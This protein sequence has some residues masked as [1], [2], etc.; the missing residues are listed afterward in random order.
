MYRKLF[1]LIITLSFIFGGVFYTASDNIVSA[2]EKKCDCYCTGSIKPKGVKKVKS[3][4][5]SSLC[6]Q[7]CRKKNEVVAV[8]AYS[9]K[10]APSNSVSCF[11]QEQCSNHF[12]KDHPI[13]TS[14]FGAEQPSDCPVN[15]HSCYSKKKPGAGKVNLS[16]SIGTVKTVNNLGEYL[17]AMYKWLLGSGSVIAVILIMI[18]GLQYALGGLSQDQVAKA[19]KRISNAVIGLVLMVSVVIIL[20]VVNPQLLKIEPPAMPLIKPLV[21]ADGQSC[22]YYRDQ[23]KYKKIGEPK[24]RDGKKGQKKCGN[25]SDL[26]ED[27][28]GQRVADGLTCAWE[29]CSD[30][31]DKQNGPM[32]CLHG[33]NEDRCTRCGELYD[34]NSDISKAGIEIS[35]ALCSKYSRGTQPLGR[36]S[37]VREDCV[38]TKDGDLNQGIGVM[39]ITSKGACGWMTLACGVI[40]YTGMGGIKPP[41]IKTC[42]EY[43][44]VPVYNKIEGKELLDDLDNKGSGVGCAGSCSN[45]SIQEV[46]ADDPC[47]VG[48][49]SWVGGIHCQ[50][51]PPPSTPP[52][53]RTIYDHIKV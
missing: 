37:T 22:E 30:T 25:Y 2:Q 28:K 36:N 3:Q 33:T 1:G 21:L 29:G 53:P 27:E 34:G 23:V 45:I 42:R 32:K 26:I 24:T 39:K 16:V 47:N 44:D 17:P 50:Q 9:P 12:R 14:K 11:T 52:P 48:P 40:E 35:G 20:T 4:T 8:C 15:Y 19:K 10:D 5:T 51:P 43:D 18:G 38:W 46:C 6:A 31:G 41:T 13:F 49:C 7:V